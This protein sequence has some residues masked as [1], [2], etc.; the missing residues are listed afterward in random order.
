MVPDVIAPTVPG[1]DG[2]VEPTLCRLSP[3]LSKL[4]FWVPD[5]NPPALFVGDATHADQVGKFAKRV[6][7][8]ADAHVADLA[9]TGDGQWLG[10]T[11]TS[12]PPPGSVRI[13]ALRLSDQSLTELPGISF[14]WAG[15]GAT[16]LIADPATSRLYLKDLDLGVEHRISEIADD[17]DPH[18]APVLSVSFDQRRFA[19][20]TRRVN[21]GTT[22]VHLA[23]HDGRHW[24]MHPLTEVPG[25]SLRVFPFW[26]CDSA[27][28]A[29][30]VI[31][32]E[33]HHSSMVAL[34]RRDGQG[35]VLY[36]SD[37]VDGF[38]T[39]ATHPDGR[40]I[41][42]IRTHAIDTAA[43]PFEQ[44]LV[45]LD[46]LERSVAAITEDAAIVG[47][48]RWLDARTLLVEGGPAIWTVKLRAIEEAPQQPP[49]SSDASRPADSSPAES[50]II[51]TVIRDIEPRFTFACDLPADWKRV[52]MPDAA[53]DFADPRV[54][55]PICVF[56]PPYASMVF[57][58]ATRPLLPGV[59][60]ETTLE[61]LSQVQ[62][63][64]IGPIHRVTLPFGSAT[65]TI[66]TQTAG[67]DVMKMRLVLIEDGGHLFSIAAMAP[68][69]LWDAIKPLLD[70][71][72]D[73]FS[74]LDALGP[75]APQ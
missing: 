40:L 12:G 48:L 63:F 46:P 35:E 27:A 21:E 33:R 18:F 70:R 34:P 11:L 55:R 14:A 53:V 13:G 4:A 15:S 30:Y 31:D 62:G 36:S 75:T 44:R 42:F 47:N 65:Q 56:V 8:P 61:F 5:A 2:L 24:K 20:V 64:E 1:K 60:L 68:A 32:L 58:V 67:S 17:G 23:H 3:D 28:M 71:I 39:P 29:L 73:S 10:F 22:Y 7:S 45:L 52:P 43:V 51:R 26:S 59:T 19:M 54:M 57:T 25:A 6:F 50:A 74:L 41:A 16:M 66:A 49:D 38:A 37:S 69:P 9:W 72:V